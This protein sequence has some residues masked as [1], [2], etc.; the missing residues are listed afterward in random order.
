MQN[1]EYVCGLHLSVAALSNIFTW[2][3]YPL[4]TRVSYLVGNRSSGADSIQRYHLTSIGNLIVEMR[5]SYDRL[6]STMGL[7]MLVRWQLYIESVPWSLLTCIKLNTIHI[8]LLHPQRIYP[9]D[10]CLRTP[11][12]PPSNLILLNTPIGRFVQ[13]L[14]L[15]KNNSN[16]NSNVMEVS[17]CYHPKSNELITTR[18]CT[19]HGSCAVVAWTKFVEISTT[20]MEL[21]WSESIESELWWKT[22]AKKGVWTNMAVTQ[23]TYDS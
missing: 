11:K 6:I 22:S 7:H 2:Y 10:G 14:V 1:V 13:G 18:L 9:H 15:L 19:C 5:R 20:G 8:C 23:Q 21:Q 12:M 17:F 3:M 4:M 16:H